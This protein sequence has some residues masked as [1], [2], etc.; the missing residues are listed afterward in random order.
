MKLLDYQIAHAQR[1]ETAI[2]KHSR[3]I[4]ASETG[5]GKTY[6]SVHVCAK[7]NLIP[8]VICP[9]SVKNT[10]YTILTEAGY[11]KSEYY[12]TNYEKLRTEKKF[13]NYDEETKQYSWNFTEQF[14][15]YKHFLFIYDEA[16]RC[17]SIDS[18]N[19]QILSALSE[20]D[21][22]ILLL[23]ATLTDRVEYF[24]PFGKV[25]L[26]YKSYAEGLVWLS[27]HNNSPVVLNKK[28]F[29]E[30]GSRMKISDTENIFKNNKIICNNLYIEKHHEIERKYNKIY[31][32]M[33]ESK[34]KKQ[35]KFNV[36]KETT[37]PID[38][39]N[40]N[41]NEEVD[42]TPVE[43]EKT[44]YL[45]NIMALRQDIELLKVNSICELTKKYIAQNKSIVIFVNFTNTIQELK[46]KLKTN[47]VVWGLQ[48][49]EERNKAIDDFCSDV[50][51]IIICNIKAGSEG[52]SLHDTKGVY[53]RVSL[54]CPTWSAQDLLQAL[55]RIHRATGQSDCIQEILYCKN[56]VEESM[57]AVIQQKINNIKLFNDGK[58]NVKNDNL[59][60]LLKNAYKKR[61]QEEEKK[62]FVFQ[63]MDFDKIQDTIDNLEHK[64]YHKKKYLQRYN[65]PDSERNKAQYELDV[66]LE[67]MKFYCSRLDI[68]VEEQIKT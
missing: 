1:I 57:S 8:F 23:S 48:K 12:I 54:I 51:R 14:Q 24:I 11:K 9:K 55:G 5:T 3:A 45:K 44:S 28:I 16:H 20:Q 32:L 58:I 46:T 38:L 22:K 34:N 35:E 39:T 47:C 42:D 66:L 27:E 26:F 33:Q 62:L 61:M 2:T 41:F 59:E 56:T 10:W 31:Q 40:I 49:I 63:T 29:N 65:L 7:L 37:K 43:Q 36:N 68:L 4:D 53:P 19:S 18:I 67:E 15:N 25:L 60:V 50:S 64:I 6:V 13:I 52:L 17:K 21:V 30:Y